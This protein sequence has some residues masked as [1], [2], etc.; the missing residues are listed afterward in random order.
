MLEPTVRQAVVRERQG[1]SL[2]ASAGE[3]MLGTGL[4]YGGCGML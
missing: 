4:G 3:A 1:R 2:E